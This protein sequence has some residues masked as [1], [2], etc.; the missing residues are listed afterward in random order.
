MAIDIKTEQVISMGQAS[1][2]LPGRP[3][4]CTLWRWRLRGVRG[5]KL[6]CVV[7]GGTPY[8]SVEA[9]ERFAQH[10]GDSDT[11]RPRTLRQ[12]RQAIALAE[13]NLES[14]SVNS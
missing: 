13:Q 5:R 11:V 12:R 1:A 7:I 9:L 2:M 8:T 10:Q 14:G 4:L 6:E 3:S